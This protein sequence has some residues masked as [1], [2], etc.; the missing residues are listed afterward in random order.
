MAV[1]FLNYKVQ[2]T[3]ERVLR[4]NPVQFKRKL[5]LFTGSGVLVHNP[6]RGGTVEPLN[7]GGVRL[8]G[9]RPVP[10]LRKQFKLLYISFKLRL[11]HLVTQRLGLYDLYSFFRGLNVRQS[12]H[13]PVIF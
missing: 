13:L 8:G 2:S 3:A 1:A 12:V 7:S 10:L 5:R 11:Y 6:L 9:L 4:R